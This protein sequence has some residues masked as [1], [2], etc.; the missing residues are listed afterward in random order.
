M[1]SCK[2]KGRGAGE[3]GGGRGWGNVGFYYLCHDAVRKCNRFGVGAE[4]CN[5]RENSRHAGFDTEQPAR[6]RYVVPLHENNPSVPRSDAL[7]YGGRRCRLKF[8]P[9]AAPKKRLLLW[10]R[11]VCAITR[12]ERERE[13]EKR[14]A[15]LF[16]HKLLLPADHSRN[17]IIKAYVDQFDSTVC[18]NRVE[19]R[20]AHRFFFFAIDQFELS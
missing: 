17:R 3:G 4:R 16:Y 8:Q 2:L 15:S 13:G 18:Y 12:I 10:S 1:Y 20:C 7:L 5:Y 11:S 19:T 14:G 6:R 9:D